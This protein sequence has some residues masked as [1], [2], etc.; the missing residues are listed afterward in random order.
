MYF[1]FACNYIVVEQVWGETWVACSLKLTAIGRLILAQ[2]T[3]RS[4]VARRV[5]TIKKKLLRTPYV[6]IVVA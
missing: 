1:S 5:E 3:R 4:V 6:G 2:H